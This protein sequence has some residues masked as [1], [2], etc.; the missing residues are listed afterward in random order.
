MMSW[1]FRRRPETLFAQLK[2]IRHAHPKMLRSFPSDFTKHDFATLQTTRAGETWFWAL[3]RRGTWLAK[4]PAREMVEYMANHER[5]AVYA[6]I[7]C[8]GPNAGTVKE[9][10]IDEVVRLSKTGS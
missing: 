10:G 1:L 3:K 5:D 9:V 7:T 2:K 6:V 4:A 8:T